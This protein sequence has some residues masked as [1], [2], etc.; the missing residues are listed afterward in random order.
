MLLL[1][2]AQLHVKVVSLQLDIV[3]DTPEGMSVTLDR[4]GGGQGGPR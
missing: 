2:Y 1:L 4:A 3:D